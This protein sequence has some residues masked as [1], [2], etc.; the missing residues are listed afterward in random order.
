MK[1]MTPIVIPNPHACASLFKG[2][3]PFSYKS[4]EAIHPNTITENNFNIIIIIFD[5]NKIKWLFI[6]K[7]NSY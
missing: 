7:K 5:L 3:W 6:F 1:A 2:H 4:S